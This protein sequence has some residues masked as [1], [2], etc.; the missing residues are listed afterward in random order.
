MINF[1]KYKIKKT[2]LRGN[3]KYGRTTTL[4]DAIT[5]KVLDIY[6]G[7][8]TKS[9]V[10]SL[11]QRLN[12]TQEKIVGFDKQTILWGL[13]LVR[14]LEKIG[15]RILDWSENQMELEYLNERKWFTDEEIANGLINGNLF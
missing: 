7:D 14:D 3:P 12:P 5:G 4:V 15:I 8:L 10:V 9:T 2:Y 1:K 13:Q 11:W 6:M